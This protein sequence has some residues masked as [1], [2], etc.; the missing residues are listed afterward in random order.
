MNK[1]FNMKR[2]FL[3]IIIL[4]SLV[5]CGTARYADSSYINQ[6]YDILN[7]IDTQYPNLSIYY[8]EGVLRV[9]SVKEYINDAGYVNY[10]LDYDFIRVYY[11]NYLDKLEI[12]QR[13]F[14]ELYSSCQ[15]GII[16]LTTVYK[17][18]NLEKN[19]VSYHISYRYIGDTYYYYY[20]NY[21]GVRIYPQ[22][23]YRY[24]DPAPVRPNQ[25]RVEPQRRDGRNPQ[26]VIPNNGSNRS[27]NSSGNNQS[28]SG[29]N[30]TR[31]R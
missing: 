18:A 30:N 20:Y 12:V 14:P 4:I 28:R 11:R 27:N 1:F 8:R 29:S 10:V 22:P 23:R 9:N 15:L 21:P 7:I 26:R 19:M 13:Y 3:F 6:N 25:Q 31:R 17:Y 2:I 16:E 24:I 5:S